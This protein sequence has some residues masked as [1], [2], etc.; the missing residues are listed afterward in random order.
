[1]DE[2]GG[3]DLTPSELEDLQN[4][5]IKALENFDQLYNNKKKAPKSL[6][7]TNMGKII[8]HQQPSLMIQ[9]SKIV[10]LGSGLEMSV[11]KLVQ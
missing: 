6:D 4:D 10:Q 11:K 7:R 2:K 5:I 9:A 8:D 3:D 1:M